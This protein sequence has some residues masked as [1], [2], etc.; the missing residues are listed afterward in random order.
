MHDDVLTK[1]GDVQT[2]FDNIPV[3]ALSR[4]KAAAP[5][6]CWP[7]VPPLPAED[8]LVV[9][10]RSIPGSGIFDLTD[11]KSWH[12]PSVTVRWPDAAARTYQQN[13]ISL[14]CRT[15]NR[16]QRARQLHP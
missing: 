6:W 12:A 8:R 11:P 14:V 13:R 9:G 15:F 16:H 5:A 4:S 7:L 10:N 1:P 3:R 2:M